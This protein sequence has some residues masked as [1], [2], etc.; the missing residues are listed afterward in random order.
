MQGMPTV[1]DSTVG[2]TRKARSKSRRYLNPGEAR[3]RVFSLDGVLYLRVGGSEHDEPEFHLYDPDE[4]V[5]LVFIVLEEKPLIVTQCQDHWGYNHCSDFLRVGGSVT[6]YNE[7]SVNQ[8]E[9]DY[10]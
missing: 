5:S 9:R 4:D 3:R 7:A 8:G 6:K 2:M 1:S 10:E